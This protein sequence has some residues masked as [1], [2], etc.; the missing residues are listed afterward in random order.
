MEILVGT[1]LASYVC[2]IE[3]VKLWWIFFLIR[4]E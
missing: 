4:D 1:E 2:V 3:G